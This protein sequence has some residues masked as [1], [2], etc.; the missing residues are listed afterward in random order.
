MPGEGTIVGPAA[1]IE[2]DIARS[3]RCRVRVAT[4]D[5]P[6]DEELAL[7]YVTG[8]AWFV[9]RWQ[10]SHGR[11]QAG[12]LCLDAI[13]PRPPWLALGREGEDLVVDVGDVADECDV[14]PPMCEPASPEVVDERAAEVLSTAGEN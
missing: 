5:Q 9:G 10:D 6:L 12:E 11:V 8:G 2:V 14:V 3:V 4:I 1:D 13:G 7:R